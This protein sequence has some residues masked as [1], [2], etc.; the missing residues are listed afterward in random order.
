MFFFILGILV[1]V[2][3]IEEDLAGHPIPDAGSLLD[4][5]IQLFRGLWIDVST[6]HI[7]GPCD[8]GDAMRGARSPA[9]PPS[10]RSGPGADDIGLAGPSAAREGGRRNSTGGRECKY[11]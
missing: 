6:V 1:D 5:R 7:S 3:G 8:T 10:K 4:Q 9:S 11:G 2:L